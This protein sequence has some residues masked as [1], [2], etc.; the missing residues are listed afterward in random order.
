[1]ILGFNGQ[2]TLTFFSQW[3]WQVPFTAYT[4]A[5]QNVTFASQAILGILTNS[6]TANLNSVVP[7]PFGDVF[8]L[9]PPVVTGLSSSTV[10]E[11][12]PSRFKTPDC[13]LRWSRQ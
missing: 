13:I 12:P 1:L 10:Q 5:Q 9:Q 11:E 7:L 4:T 2:T 8:A 6:L 3:I